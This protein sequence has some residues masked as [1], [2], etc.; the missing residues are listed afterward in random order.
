MGGMLQRMESVSNMKNGYDHC[1]GFIC[2][3][4]HRCISPDEK[5]CN[6]KCDWYCNCQACQYDYDV[7]TDNCY[8]KK[9][10]EELMEDGRL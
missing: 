1:E 9:T 3:D 2:K 6:E 7:E 8:P 4:V 5:D 10:I